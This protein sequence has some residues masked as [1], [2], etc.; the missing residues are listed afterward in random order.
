MRRLIPDWLNRQIK[1]IEY[2]VKE[3]KPVNINDL[4]E[5]LTLN[6][7]LLQKD[8]E[9]INTNFGSEIFKI[10]QD[11]NNV[12]LNFY[13]GK[14]TA[15]IQPR[16]FDCSIELQ[17]I[18]FIFFN[19]NCSSEEVCSFLH[20]SNASLYR[21]IADLNQFLEAEHSFSIKTSPFRL[22]GAEVN[23]RHFMAQLISEKYNKYEWPFCSIDEDYLS[24][25]I[26]EC[27]K[28]FKV[29]LDYGVIQKM[30]LLLAVGIV[31]FND[32]FSIDIEH[33]DDNKV[34]KLVE[35]IN[36]QKKIYSIYTHL[37]GLPV[38]SSLLIDI[39]S[40][41][42][43]KHVVYTNEELIKLAMNDSSVNK[44]YMT[45]SLMIEKI[46]QEFSIP[47]YNKENLIQ[48]LYITLF[49]EK[50][51][52]YS[53]SFFFERGKAVLDVFH[54]QKPEFYKSVESYMK[55][56]ILNLKKDVN[57]SFLRHMLYTFFVHWEGLH[58]HFIS[59]HEAVPAMLISDIDVYHAKMLKNTIINQF[60]D[61]IN[62]K[63]IND[64]IVRLSEIDSIDIP[65]VISNFPIDNLKNKDLV[66]VNNVIQKS[67]INNLSRVIKKYE[68]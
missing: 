32:G 27:L 41:Y 30:K 43:Q 15:C 48:T 62:I 46:S 51:E 57:H 6:K 49:F 25:F 22:E 67:D 68:S 47:I 14:C 36:N 18:E 23:I 53:D 20:I 17:L 21:K 5:K 29:P 63:I 28:I 31:R 61:Q 12:Y 34:Q 45:L 58:E 35:E 56:L 1:I 55:T 65:I 66:I 60:K 40:F 3:S 11:A 54:N 64:D 10:N 19:N 4:C 37:F 44:I 7:R 13:E 42:A 50:L 26:V 2:I 38:D 16:I 24:S 52:I 39:F 8:I 33:I 9:R 59:S